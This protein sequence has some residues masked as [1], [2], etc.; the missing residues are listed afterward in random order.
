M[1]EVDLEAAEVVA[2]EEADSEAVEEVDL[3]EVTD[4][5]AVDVEEE[6]SIGSEAVDVVVV[7]VEVDLLALDLIA[8]DDGKYLCSFG[9]CCIFFT[10]L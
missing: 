4:S 5:E 1:E 2:E 9:M 10:N 7:E 3:E 6:D 8:G